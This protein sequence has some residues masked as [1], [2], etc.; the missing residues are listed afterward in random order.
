[1]EGLLT[2]P[3]DHVRSRA[4][5]DGAPR[6]AHGRAHPLIPFLKPFRRPSSRCCG[7]LTRSLLPQGHAAR[8]GFRMRPCPLAKREDVS[9]HLTVEIEPYLPQARWAFGRGRS[10]SGAFVREGMLIEPH[11]LRT[12]SVHARVPQDHPWSVP[13]E[14]AVTERCFV[15]RSR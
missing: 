15:R 13:H 10:S 7:R 8:S 1:M 6:G 11:D 4:P 9:G 5:R 2:D 12:P 14:G 3:V